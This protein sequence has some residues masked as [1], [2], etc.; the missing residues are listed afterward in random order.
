MHIIYKLILGFFFFLLR[1]VKN[2]QT[3]KHMG[4]KQAYKFSKLSA[5]ETSS[6]LLL[7]AQ[8]QRL[9]AEQDQLPLGSTGTSSGS[10]QETETC[11]VRACHTP[12]QPLQNHP[13][14]HFIGLATPWSAEEMLDGQHQGVDISA[15]VR[16]A[17]K[18]LL[19]K[20]LEEDLW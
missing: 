19:Q 4:L 14:G 10:C 3:N 7:G 16:T 11:T 20:R 18:G 5:E 15:H 12:R 17:H 9:H 1:V 8:D 2:K 6:H 13:S